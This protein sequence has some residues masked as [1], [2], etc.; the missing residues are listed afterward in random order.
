MDH[1]DQQN[2]IQHAVQQFECMVN[3]VYLSKA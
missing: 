2:W 1:N 3:T